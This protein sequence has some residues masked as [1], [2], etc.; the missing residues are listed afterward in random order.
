MKTEINLTT[1]DKKLIN[2]ALLFLKCHDCVLD[3]ATCNENCIKLR[4]MFKEKEK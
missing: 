2:Q 3:D 4:E 1:E